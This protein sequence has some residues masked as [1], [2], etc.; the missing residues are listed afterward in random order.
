[1]RVADGGQSHGGA[2]RE[3]VV[4]AIEGVCYQIIY[5]MINANTMAWQGHIKARSPQGL[6][7]PAVLMFKF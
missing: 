6:S 4:H 2:F 7:V 5:D 3:H 1:M